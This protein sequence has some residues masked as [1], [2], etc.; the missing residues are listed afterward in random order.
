MTKDR[1]LVKGAAEGAHTQQSGL[2]APIYEI[3]RC[4]CI[5]TGPCAQRTG[6]G[7]LACLEAHHIGTTS[8]LVLADSLFRPAILLSAA[9]HSYDF[10]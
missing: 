2:N 10:Y 4:T 1:E 6:A 5:P 7:N 3:A 9:I 8:P